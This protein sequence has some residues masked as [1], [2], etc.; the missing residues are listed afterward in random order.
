MNYPIIGF[1]AAIFTTTAF[2][3][4][5]LKIIRT[6]KTKD[7]SKRMYLILVIGIFLWLVYGLLMRDWPIVLA[8]SITFILTFTIFMLKLK[9]G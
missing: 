6:K 4:Q 7:I 3:P 1:V 5:A 8:N 2:I 9:Y